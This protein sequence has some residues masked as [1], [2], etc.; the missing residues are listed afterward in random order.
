[1]TPIFGE[2]FNM[3]LDF[4]HLISW[5]FIS[6]FVATSLV[7]VG[8]TTS[9]SL[10]LKC[11][12]DPSIWHSKN[13][14]EGCLAYLQWLLTILYIIRSWI[15]PTRLLF[16]ASVPLFNACYFNAPTQLGILNIKVATLPESIKE[17]LSSICRYM[18]ETLA[19]TTTC[20]PSWTLWW[21]LKE[22][23]C[24]ERR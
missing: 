10:S 15:V 4:L 14:T 1:M 22:G 13:G 21:N 17:N 9:T 18:G 20:C 19:S 3:L 8:R 11:S 16:P 24:I 2:A 7:Y 23:K 6:R 5:S 12:V